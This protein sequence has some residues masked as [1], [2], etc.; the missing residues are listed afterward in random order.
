MTYLLTM[1]V[2]NDKRTQVYTVKEY[3]SN[4]TACECVVDS[5]KSKLVDY[6]IKPIDNKRYAI[7]DSFEAI[8]TSKPYGDL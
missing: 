3:H 2:F 6:N 5:Y 1:Q 4:L 7:I 8:T